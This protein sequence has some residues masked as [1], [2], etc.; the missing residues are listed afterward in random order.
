M[1]HRVK[2]KT[3]C[4]KLHAP[5]GERSEPST[6]HGRLTTD[7]IAL[8]FDIKGYRFY[9]LQPILITATTEKE[10]NP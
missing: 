1:E 7:M 8:Q 3:P 2:T 9:N 6:D 5:S 10:T 4:A